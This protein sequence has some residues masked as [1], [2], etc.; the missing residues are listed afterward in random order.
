MTRS[1]GAGDVPRRDARRGRTHGGPEASPP[2]QSPVG[3]RR[4]AH[5]A[6]VELPRALRPWAYAAEARGPH[7]NCPP[8]CAG[9]LTSQGG[10]AVSES[11]VRRPKGSAF[12]AGSDVARA[13]T[14]VASGWGPLDA[15]LGN[16]ARS[17]DPTELG[18]LGPAAGAVAPAETGFA[19]TLGRSRRAVTSL[20]CPHL[21]GR[22]APASARRP[23]RRLRRR[24]PSPS[25][26]N[27]AE[28]NV[29]TFSISLRVETPTWLAWA[30]HS[31][32]QSVFAPNEF[33]LPRGH[34]ADVLLTSGVFA[35]DA[36]ETPTAPGLAS[37]Q[38]WRPQSHLS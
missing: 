11:D 23:C 1:G 37:K 19:R 27:P 15:S 20:R 21:F 9:V 3:G 5:P 38:V 7:R 17:A 16:R 13:Q 18:V 24:P 25:R 4:K 26:G 8:T 29:S 2:S 35:A 32:S 31:G 22:D 12:V 10:A 33:F 34:P 28:F 30:S 6:G 14:G 36:R